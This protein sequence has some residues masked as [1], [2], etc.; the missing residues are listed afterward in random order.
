M[1]TLANQLKHNPMLQSMTKEEFISE[2]TADQ[3]AIPA[4][5]T[6]SVLLNKK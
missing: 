3:P 4:Y 5:F 6:N 2:L 1:D